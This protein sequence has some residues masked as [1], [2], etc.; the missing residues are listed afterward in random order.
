MDASDKKQDKAFEQVRAILGKL[1]QSIDEARSRRLGPKEPPR[2]SP[3]PAAAEP[4]R[5]AAPAR[6]EPARPARRSMYGRA[7]PLNREDEPGSPTS[8]WSRNDNQPRPRQNNGNNG[9]DE[10]IG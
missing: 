10:R 1:D 7:K 6:P 8:Q 9:L 5:P 4:P 3:A 2:P